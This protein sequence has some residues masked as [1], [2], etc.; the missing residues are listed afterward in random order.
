MSSIMENFVK[1]NLWS[2]SGLLKCLTWSHNLKH[3]KELF[4]KVKSEFIPIFKLQK[5]I[6]LYKIEMEVRWWTH[7]SQGWLIQMTW[8]VSLMLIKY[9]N[10]L[11]MV[12][13]FYLITLQGSKLYWK[14]CYVYL[15][16]DTHSWD[17]IY[18]LLGDSRYRVSH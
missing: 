10:N 7:Y 9:K 5:S 15:S 16:L 1:G 6:S 3:C 13:I 14:V 17:P 18:F 12:N 4:C 2:D 11:W 8:N